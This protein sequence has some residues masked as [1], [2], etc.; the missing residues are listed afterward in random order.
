MY[1][2]VLKR[3]LPFFLTFAGGLLVASFFVSVTAPSMP[4]GARTYR[5]NRCREAKRIQ[6]DYLELKRENERLQRELNE[7][8]Q[9][10]D[11]ELDKLV[12]PVAVPDVAPPPPPPTRVRIR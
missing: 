7:A 3:V 2:G 6:N 9:G 12:P 5:F 1:K 8:R 10:A 11:V 4:F